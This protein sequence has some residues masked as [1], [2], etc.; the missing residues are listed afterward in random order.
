MINLDSQ[1]DMYDTYQS[2]CGPQTDLGGYIDSSPEKASM[3]SLRGIWICTKP[4]DGWDSGICDQGSII[5]NSA[6]LTDYTQRRKT[7]CHEIGHSVGLWHGTGYGGCMVSGT[8]SN[9]AYA[10]HHVW[11]IN[12]RF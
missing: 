12:T 5:V 8:S 2:A 6:L 3:G 4:L 10:S 9:T 11:H 1:T 7:F